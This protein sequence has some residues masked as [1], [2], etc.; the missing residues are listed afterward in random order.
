MTTT[1]P[2]SAKTRRLNY[3]AE[4]CAGALLAGAPLLAQA[5]AANP[6]AAAASAPA[7]D[8]GQLER[9]TITAEK[10]LTVLDTTPAAITV[11]NGSRLAEQGATNLADVVALSPNT[12]FTTGQGA[13]Q[14]FIRGIGN[15]FIL[16]GGDPGVALYTDGSYVS[17]QTSSNVSLFDT[18]RFEVLRGPQGALYGR[19]A[20]GGAMNII[21]ARPTDTFQARVGALFG[22]YGRKES[23]GFVS[24]P[25]GDGSTKLRLSY[26][27]K[28][29]DGYTSNP[30]SG[31]RSGPVIAGGLSTSG[32]DKLDD[33]STRALRLQ[34][35]TDFGG[36]GNLRLI[37]GHYREKDA[38]PSTPVLVD[39]V[40]NS[41]LLF[42]VVPGSDPRVVKSQGSTNKIDVNTLQALYEQPIGKNTLSIAASWRHSGVS[43][44]FDSDGT[45]S[46][47]ANSGFETSSRDTSIDVHLASDEESALQWLV[48]ATWL[49]FDQRQDID[50]ATQVPVGFLVP[51]QPLNVPFP[52]G[53]KFLLGGKVR[54]TSEA[55]YTDLRYALSPTWAL[56]AGLRV[57]HDSKRANE[58]QNIAAFGIDATG[59]PSASWTSLPGSLGVEYKFSPSTMAYARLSHGFKSG[60]VNLGA[61]QPE[62]VKP[63]TVTS[64]ELGMKTEFWDRRGIFSAAVFSSDYKDMQV[65]QVGV[66]NTILA[67][68][69]AAKINGLELETSLRPVP[70][71]TL[72]AGVGLMDPKYTDFT[73]TDLRNNPTQPVNVKGNQ[74]AQVSKAQASLAADFAQSIGAYKTVLH[75]D[76]VWR[77]KFY[78]TEFNTADAVQPAYGL[79]NLSASIRPAEGRWKVYAQL[80]NAANTTAFT[81]MSIA[82]PLLAGARQVTY[83]PPREFALG[84]TLDF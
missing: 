41:Q 26:Q 67:N 22:N 37:L 14:L 49:R 79:L 33:L 39:A 78:F 20:T 54:T 70:A 73:N 21:S 46:L 64:V 83:T 47:T 17:D 57:N 45:E 42:G 53:V 19:N 62:L 63:E 13:S 77:G 36:G 8:I 29:L 34:S 80:R 11:L 55:V 50:I 6:P 24:G 16:A 81:S 30:L 65:S 75:A 59:S 69:S 9:V 4:L 43:R 1:T 32:P 3:V 7:A 38:G 23:E 28:E 58:Y 2:R 25:V 76:Y 82:S 27:L 35:A 60:A 61:L 5:Q 68:A 10:R 12:T 84:A 31:T 15:V 48:G 71:L 40:M 66:A 18:Q 51:G 72:S 74:L 56:L 44:A 52:G